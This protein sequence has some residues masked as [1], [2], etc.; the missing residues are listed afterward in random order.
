MSIPYYMAVIMRGG[1]N[2]SVQHVTDKD[3][4]WCHRTDH[5]RETRALREQLKQSE[6]T[7]NLNLHTQK[8]NDAESLRAERADFIGQ[9]EALRAENERL[10]EVVND[11]RKL[12]DE[13]ERGW[14]TYQRMEGSE[15]YEEAARLSEKIDALLSPPA[16]QQSADARGE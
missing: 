4:E 8:L 12:I 9:V 1:D 15:L 6:S 7:Y 16:P 5:E 10:R 14:G 13:K 3:G 11:A 2:S